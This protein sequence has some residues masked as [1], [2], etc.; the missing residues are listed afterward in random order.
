ML[1]DTQEPS[2]PTPETPA[3]DGAP[4]TDAPQPSPVVQMQ[5]KPSAKKKWLVTGLIVLLLVAAA[6]AAWWFALRD[7]DS[8][9]SSTAKQAQIKAPIEDTDGIATPDTI[10][11]SSLTEQGS[12]E[13][14]YWQDANGG[15]NT[16][17]TL[18]GE[19][20]PGEVVV[21]GQQVAVAGE[22]AVWLSTDAGKSYSKLLELKQGEQ[23]TSLVFAV[24]GKELAVA[25]LPEMG[26]N[27]VKAIN[28]QTQ[29][30][31]DLFTSEMRGIFLQA[32]SPAKKQVLFDEGCFN[33]DGNVTSALKLRDL[34]TKT[35][36]VVLE[37]K[38]GAFD[39]VSMRNDFEAFLF[40]RSTTDASQSDFIGAEYNA[41]YSVEQFTLAD[42]SLKVLA[43]NITT[44]VWAIGYAADG[45]TPYYAEGRK[46]SVVKESK[47]VVLYESTKNISA[48][49]F[50]S[51]TDVI[52]ET[53]VLERYDIAAKK[54]STILSDTNSNIWGVA[55]K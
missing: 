30:S 15:K 50:V 13:G 1:M 17:V 45:Q 14:L 4:P 39:Q 20:Y 49:Y 2:N 22:Q 5:T 16:K 34:E 8:P 43:E 37:T 38:T 48:V 21:Q 35:D 44:E 9:K 32:Y 46:I 27:T 6:G 26:D 3:T 47:P 53:D 23:I 36:T 28:L 18:A 24:D 54:T 12:L 42:K 31:Q 33:C 41:P 10:I 29:K 40:V 25:V 55:T 51:D 19:S 11:F 52:F 7:S